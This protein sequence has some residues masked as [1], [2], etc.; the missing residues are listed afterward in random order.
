MRTMG[1]LGLA[2]A[3][4]GCSFRVLTPQLHT[5]DA[6]P[7]S[8]TQYP[9]LKVHMKSGE[10]Y[11]LTNWHAAR[12]TAAASRGRARATR[13]H[14]SHRKTRPVSIATSEVA[15]FETNTSESVHPGGAVVLT[16]WSTLTGT[17]AVYCAADPKACFGSCPTFYLDGRRSRGTAGRRGFLVL[18]R[19]G[20]RGA[21]RG[22][23]RRGPGGGRALRPHDAQRGLRDARGA[24]RAAAR[25]RAA[26]RR[27]GAGGPGRRLLPGV[28]APRARRLSRRRRRLP[29]GGL[30]GRRC[31][32]GLAGRHATTSPREKPSSSTSLPWRDAWASS[33][34]GARRCSRRTSSTRRWRTSAATPASTWRASSAAGR[35]VARR[36]MGMARVLG[37]IDVEVSKA[38]VP[39]VRSGASTRRGRSPAT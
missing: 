34:A 2:M 36:A 8:R 18:D 17:L 19:A 7:Q 21:R 27:T 29:A 26:A 13:S 12:R 24:A 30:G 6:V 38:A 16:I 15:L 20:A 14:A 28:R 32:A 23:D 4:A 1:W 39:S 11:T 35:S 37:G 25:G 31:R 33:S 5:P 3:L 22:R 9:V 10:L